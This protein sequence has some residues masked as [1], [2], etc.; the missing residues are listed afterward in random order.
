MKEKDRDEKDQT[1]LAEGLQLKWLRRMDSM[2]DDGTITSS[3]MATLY[4]FL[5]DNGWNLDPAR[6]PK[7]LRDKLTSKISP[8]DFDDEEQFPRPR[9]VS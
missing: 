5:S 3:D 1:E 8:T 7:R 2:L 9:M 6:L 4:R